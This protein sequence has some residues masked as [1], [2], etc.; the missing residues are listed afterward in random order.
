MGNFLGVS[1]MNQTNETLLD[2]DVFFDDGFGEPLHIQAKGRPVSGKWADINQ[3]VDKIEADFGDHIA[4][5]LVVEIR[6]ASAPPIGTFTVN[7]DSH[8]TNDAPLIKIFK[9]L[10]DNGVHLYWADSDELAIE[11]PG[12]RH[13]IGFVP[14]QRWINGL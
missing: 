7:V 2:G 11:G 9:S 14:V 1:V 8:L 6:R 4:G 10:A 13:D 5:Q 12:A 3:T